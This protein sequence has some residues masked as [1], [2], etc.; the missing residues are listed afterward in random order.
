[1]APE[2]KPEAK[3]LVETLKEVAAEVV[4]PDAT[5]A[6]PGVADDR[7]DRQQASR[8]AQEQ[9]EHAPATLIALAVLCLVGAAPSPWRPGCST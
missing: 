1:M 2:R 8:H 7:H 3:P 9:G 4:D 5:D 6:I